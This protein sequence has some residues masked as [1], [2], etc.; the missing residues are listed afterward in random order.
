MSGVA[1]VTHF[2]LKFNFWYLFY[3]LDEIT[4]KTESFAKHKN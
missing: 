1:E 4:D 2:P 3:P